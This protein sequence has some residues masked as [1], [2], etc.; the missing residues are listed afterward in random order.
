MVHS[1]FTSVERSL[2]WDIDTAAS[3]A[4]G[5]GLPC[6]YDLYEAEDQ[7]HEYQGLNPDPNQF[8]F[9]AKFVVQVRKTLS[10][11]IYLI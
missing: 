7:V 5:C 3:E 4:T 8:D 1:R 9:G 2:W 10:V 11:F 6:E